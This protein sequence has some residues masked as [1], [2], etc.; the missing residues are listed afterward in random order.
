MS[1]PVSTAMNTIIPIGAITAINVFVFDPP[2]PE[3]EAKSVAIPKFCFVV[4]EIVVVS[5]AGAVVAFVVDA[6][7]GTSV[8]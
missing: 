1:R 4:M 6:C 5:M 3:P 8:V 2:L 7:V